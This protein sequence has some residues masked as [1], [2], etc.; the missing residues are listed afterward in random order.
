MANP[1]DNKRIE[2]TLPADTG[3]MLVV[4]LT[5]AG[6]IA[7]AGITVDR[8]DD[9]KLAVEEACNCLMSQERR[10]GRLHIYF[11]LTGEGIEMY[12]EGLYE[13]DTLT[14][15][16]LR[17]DRQEDEM[18]IERCILEALADSVNITVKNGWIALIG[19]KAAKAQ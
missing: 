19:M 9:L 8:M 14:A 15:E 18:E 16:D 6:V 1:G 11:E 4:R 10:P 2:L 12:A 3:L 7:R 17:G 5:A 13:D